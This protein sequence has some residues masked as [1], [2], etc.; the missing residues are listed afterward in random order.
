MGDKGIRASEAAIGFWNQPLE[1]L[2]ASCMQ[3]C[4]IQAILA[5]MSEG[6]QR[7]AVRPRKL[8]GNNAPAVGSIEDRRLEVCMAHL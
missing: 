7:K 3:N 4:S 2:K 8:N 6:A 1:D 5:K